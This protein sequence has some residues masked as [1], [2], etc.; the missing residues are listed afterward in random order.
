MTKG[1]AASWR[2]FSLEFDDKHASRTRHPIAEQEEIF[3]NLLNSPQRRRI[4]D[5]I[6]YLR[7][8]LRWAISP[9]TTSWMPNG[10]F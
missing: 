5:W 1:H 3:V 6:R 10:H 8:A 2:E 7:V 9:I 4:S